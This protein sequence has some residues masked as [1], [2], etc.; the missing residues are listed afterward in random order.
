M[1]DMQANYTKMV[2]FNKALQILKKFDNKKV[3]SM[4]GESYN[5]GRSSA[6]KSRNHFNHGKSR[7]AKSG[8]SYTSILSRKG[9]RSAQTYN[10]NYDKA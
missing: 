1:S 6:G 8:N 2:K 10:R 3:G 5:R 7:T 4:L 9:D